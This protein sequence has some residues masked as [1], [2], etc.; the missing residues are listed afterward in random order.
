MTPPKT[1]KTIAADVTT[2]APGTWLRL[3]EAGRT[4]SMPHAARKCQGTPRALSPIAT[5]A[6]G[7]P[8]VDATA[9]GTRRAPWGEP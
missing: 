2:E 9:T 3:S 7:A 1:I 6:R 4:T 8:Q 5:P